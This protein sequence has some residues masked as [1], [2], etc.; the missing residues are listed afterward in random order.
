[1]I[2]AVAKN[3]ISTIP[4]YASQDPEIIKKFDL[5][6][7]D[8]PTVIVTKDNGYRTYT[9]SHDF[10]KNTKENR[11][12]LIN[13]IEKEQYPL[14]SRLGPVNQKSILQGSAP[15]VLNIVNIND[16][17]SQSKFRDIAS[18]WFK[19]AKPE[20]KVV[21]AEM[22]RHL[23]RDYVLDTFNVNHDSSSKLVIYD[24]SVSRVIQKEE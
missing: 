14:I 1:M 6:P 24:P 10:T 2:E 22:D 18:T 3:Y 23:W 19:S 11:E 15:V 5:A 16:A 8:L 21:F 12:A 4:F 7:Q 9:G 20:D 17:T 13:W